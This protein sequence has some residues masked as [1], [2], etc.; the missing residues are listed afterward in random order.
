MKPKDKNKLLLEYNKNPTQANLRKLQVAWYREVHNTG[1]RD[2][3][4]WVDLNKFAASTFRTI[5]KGVENKKGD[6]ISWDQLIEDD[7]TKED[8]L[9]NQINIAPLADSAT[10]NYWHQLLKKANDLPDNYPYKEFLIQYATQGKT[11][12]YKNLT[13]NKKRYIIAKFKKLT[14]E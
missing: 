7:A 13:V 6:H 4:R 9:I 8:N 10:F 14:K 2:I 3:E 1:H 11:P 5:A 12:K